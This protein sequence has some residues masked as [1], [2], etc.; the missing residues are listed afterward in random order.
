MAKKEDTVEQVS[1]YPII[2]ELQVP[3]NLPLYILLR[4]LYGIMEESDILG[5]R[6]HERP[7]F[8]KP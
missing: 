8:S 7:V 1:G 6:R 4:P 3:Q 5:N 2:F